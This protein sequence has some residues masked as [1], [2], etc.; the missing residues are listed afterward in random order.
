M[1]LAVVVDGSL[2]AQMLIDGL[3]ELLTEL[4]NLL[5]ETLQL[6]ALQ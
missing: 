1:L 6:L 3:L 4:W 2:Q 5:C